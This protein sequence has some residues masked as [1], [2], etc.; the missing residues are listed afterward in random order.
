MNTI[1]LEVSCPV[2]DSFRVQQVAG[3][4]D[5]PLAAKATERFHVDLP[6]F[7]ADWR[8]GLIVGPS[9]SGKSTLARR[10][11][12]PQLYTNRAWSDHAAV[13]DGLGE[14]P[15]REVT[16]LFTAVGFSSP[17]SWVKPYHVLSG[18]EQFRCDLAR[19]L[20]RGLRRDADNSLVDGE[21]PIVAFDEFTSV[22]DRNVA[23]IGS[24]AVAKAIRSG[25]IACRF[26][27]VTCHY[28]VA[29]WLEPDWTIDMATRTSLRRCLRRPSIELQVFRCRSRAWSLFARH[30][31]LSGA[32]NPSARCFI[33]LWDGEPVSFCAMLPLMGKRRHWRISRIVTLP[34]YQGIGIGM[35]VAEAVA[36][37]H[38]EQGLRVSVTASHPALVAHCNRSPQ[39]RAVRLMK[40]GSR[41]RSR[42]KYR[43]SAG[44][45][46][47]SFEY[48]GA[49]G[50]D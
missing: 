28:D 35:R 11:F 36:E 12:E 14:L 13:I 41:A 48:L 44:R 5:V 23:K 9:G 2:Y 25:H 22:V 47:V 49:P 20:A 37:V 6:D 33:A 18:G 34:D 50:A 43:G 30:H 32:L 24:A 39:W 19:A 17:P 16:G 8:I 31:Y 27:A 26:I 38:R 7:A 21:M 10:L 40:T 42:S 15:I 1:D 45:A 4:F 29:E 3:M 46:V